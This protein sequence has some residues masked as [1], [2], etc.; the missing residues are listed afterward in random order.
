MHL[1]VLQHVPFEGPASLI[2]WSLDRNI[3]LSIQFM[4]QPQAMPQP[5]LYDGIIVLGGPMGV[6]DDDQHPWLSA[7]KEFLT[8]AM[9]AG[10][11]I[12]GICLGAQLL[13]QLCGATVRRNRYK[14]IGWWPI[15]FT[16]TALQS[17]LFEDF[18]AELEVMHWHGDTFD[19]PKNSQ[20]LASSAGCHNQGFLSH[21]G[22]VLGLQFHMEWNFDVAQA[23]TTHCHHELVSH[24]CYV[25]TE[26][27]IL[28]P[29]EAYARMNAWMS[30]LMDRF[31]ACG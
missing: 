29:N 12:L 10:K 30:K 13:A 20:L 21:D 25:Q 22:K 18:P 14:E 1:V 26:E 4:H 7:E 23:L 5:H 2:D 11:A 19:L 16:E 15:H 6:Y 28:R 27:E 17:P 3:K 8:A 24:S 31:F 9:H